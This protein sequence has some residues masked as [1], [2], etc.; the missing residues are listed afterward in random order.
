M[1]NVT[2]RELRKSYDAM[3][4]AGDNAYA[5]GD[6]YRLEDFRAMQRADSELKRN[7]NELI[8]DVGGDRL[9]LAVMYPRMYGYSMTVIKM[10]GRDNFAV[11][12]FN[13]YKTEEGLMRA[14]S[15][16]YSIDF[17][18]PVFVSRF[19]RGSEQ[20]RALLANRHWEIV[21]ERKEKTNG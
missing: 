2:P 4:A 13:F 12:E 11:D 16:R 17:D 21:K 6:E 19:L 7:T 20:A 18:N 3:M 10:I 1:L 9:S 15:E 8:F 5:S 14:A